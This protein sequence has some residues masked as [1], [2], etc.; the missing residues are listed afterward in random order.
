M[1]FCSYISVSISLYFMFFS[2]FI[3]V[4]VKGVRLNGVFGFLEFFYNKMYFFCV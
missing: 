3:S 4:M 2:E 1:L